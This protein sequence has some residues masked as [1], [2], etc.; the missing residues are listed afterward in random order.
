MSRLLIL[1]SEMAAERGTVRQ[2]IDEFIQQTLQRWNKTQISQ[3]RLPCDNFTASFA[4]LRQSDYLLLA[5]G[6][7]DLASPLFQRDLT[8]LCDPN[9]AKPNMTLIFYQ[10]TPAEQAILIERINHAGFSVCRY[11]Q[12]DDL[13]LAY[14][15]LNDIMAC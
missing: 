11:I 10:I 14:R 1:H 5:L 15:Q 2:V 3:V 4:T 7:N 12:A 6:A 9:L 8:A 13:T